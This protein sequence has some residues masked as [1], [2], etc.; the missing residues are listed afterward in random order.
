MDTSLSHSNLEDF[1]AEQAENLPWFTSWDTVLDWQEPYAKWFKGGTLNASYACVDHHIKQGKGQHIACMWE[2]E[3]GASQQWTYYELYKEVNCYAHALRKQGVKKGD[4]VVLYLPMMLES[5]AIMLACARLG[6]IHSVVFSGFSSVSL[7]GRIL[8][9]QA[10]FVI[11]A[12]GTLRRGKIVNL[13]NIVDAAVSK[14]PCVEKV[15]VIKRYPEE[16]IALTNKDILLNDILETGVEISPEPVDATH[17]LFILY[18]SGTTGKPKG[19]MH[20]TGG[21]LTYVYSTIKW[22]FDITEDDVYWCTAD[23]GWI[24]GHSYVTYG[25]LLHGAQ[26]VMYEGAPNFPDEGAW[27][28]IIEKYKVSIF[29]TSP[30]ALRMFMSYGDKWPNACNLS[31]LKILG[32]VGEPIN[33]EVWMWY[34]KVIGKGTCPIVDT[35]WQTETGGFMISPAPALDLIKLKPGSATLPM[36]GI[37]AEVVDAEGNPVPRG[38]KGFLVI[39]KPWPGMTIGIYKDDKR[40][41]DVYWSKF[42]GRYYPGDYAIQDSDGYFWLLGRADEVLNIAG[43]RIGTAEI[44]SAAITLGSIAEAAAIGIKDAIRGESVVI[45]AILKQGHIETADTSDQVSQAV[46]RHIGKFVQPKGV[47]IVEKL[48][49]TRSG[50]IMRR[51]LKAVVEQRDIGDVSTLEDVASVDEVR[52]SFEKI[53]ASVARVS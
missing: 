5:M 32:T 12:D 50:K 39:N 13:K 25:P 37:E 34:D 27:W 9:M 36:P 44:E 29:Y 19:L 11:T 15:F 49:K 22:A 43:H 14:T 6:A 16:K 47:Y 23:I 35:W 20:S 26:V 46:K 31:S 8:D 4:I 2:D 18:T 53:K 1:W 38:A 42:K 3:R 45:F 33:P 40:F 17:P 24:T 30:T 51:L 28:K 41:K 52:A 7:E 48:P 10:K 21:Y